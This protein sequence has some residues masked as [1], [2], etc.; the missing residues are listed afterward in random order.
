MS[1]SGLRTNPLVLVTDQKISMAQ[2]VTRV[3][4]LDVLVLFLFF[5]VMIEN[6]SGNV[7]LWMWR[8]FCN[9]EKWY[10]AWIV[11]LRRYDVVHLLNF[12]DFSA[13]WTWYTQPH[14]TG[15]CSVMCSGADS[16]PHHCEADVKATSDYCRV[17]WKGGQKRREK[18]LV[19]GLQTC[20]VNWCCLET[21]NKICT[22]DENMLRK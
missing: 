17:H 14:T 18:P 13:T 15:S 21:V 7:K 1:S 10:E 12:I 4:V 8:N 22:T 11:P 2:Q 5:V 19:L 9:S 6:P 3:V 16:H 20:D